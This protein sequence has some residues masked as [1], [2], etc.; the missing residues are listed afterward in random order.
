MPK[1]ARTDREAGFSLPEVMI[2]IVI[3]GI[4]FTAIL[5]GMITTITVSSLHR[6]QATADAFARDAAEWVKDSVKNQYV[7]CA[8]QNIYDPVP[9]DAS[10]QPYVPK[11]ASGQ[12]YLVQV[13][14][15]SSSGV[16]YWNGAAP[17]VGSAYSP[18]F[19]WTQSQCQS[20]GDKGL[21]RIT[22]VVS[23]PDRQATETVQIL[24]RRVP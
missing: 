24:K 6:K 18:S 16:E 22:I 17:I 14:T 12:P 20:N 1:S 21:Q 10:G 8:G 4:A 13:G 11:D 23:S 3:V 15:G 19:P 2:T 7:D 5:G 9:K